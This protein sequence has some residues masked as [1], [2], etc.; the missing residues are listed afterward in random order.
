MKP[1]FLKYDKPLITAMIQYHTPDECILKIKASL[2]D[3][4][5]A[6]GIQLDKLKKEYQTP[7]YYKKIFASCDGKPIYV[8]SYRNGDDETKTDDERAENLLMA[9]DCGATLCDV[10]GDMFDPSPQ[11]ELTTDPTAVKKQTELIKKI[12]QNGGEVLIS[13]HTYKSI[14]TDECIMIAKEHIRRGADIIKIVN[15]ADHADEV[16]KYIDAIQKIVAM[17]DRKLLFLVSGSAEII[18]Y[19]G[20]NFG[21]CMYLCVQHHGDLDTT[22]QPLISKIKAIRENIR[23]DF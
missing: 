10:M 9:L 21:V 8:T 16:P 22:E 17:T 2:A 5:E 12:H 6:I 3:G 19:I 4:A 18:R 13:S 15:N 23:F 1:T 11:Y 20:P 7:E 14:S